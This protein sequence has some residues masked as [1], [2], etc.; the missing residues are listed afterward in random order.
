MAGAGSRG[1]VLWVTHLRAV[2]ASRNLNSLVLGCTVGHSFPR[3]EGLYLQQWAFATWPCK[4]ASKDL[5]K[6]A[7]LNS[8]FH[9][10]GLPRCSG[11]KPFA[12][13]VFLDRGN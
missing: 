9:R 12:R 10:F 1:V 3:N 8:Q 7:L 13:D 5:Q 11:I 4:R 6:S 2:G